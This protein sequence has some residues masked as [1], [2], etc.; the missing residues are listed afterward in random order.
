MKIFKIDD[1]FFDLSDFQAL[2]QGCLYLKGRIAPLT[3]QPSGLEAL[4]AILVRHLADPQSPQAAPSIEPTDVEPAA[5][6]KGLLLKAAVP[7]LISADLRSEL[8]AA[9]LMYDARE[10]YRQSYIMVVSTKNMS[11][12]LKSTARFWFP[13]QNKSCGKV[14][15]RFGHW[16]D[17][18]NDLGFL[19]HV[20]RLIPSRRFNLEIALRD[21]IDPDVWTDLQRQISDISEG[22][23]GK[24][25]WPYP[26]A[27]PGKSGSR[28]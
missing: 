2:E 4:K 7:P 1:T 3:F 24:T 5:T 27:E 25:K 18:F 22:K 19:N 16:S 21:G 9:Y 23:N 20:E 12:T 26:L 13:L 17:A 6:R 15:D 14:A 10:N 11:G 28:F 8:R